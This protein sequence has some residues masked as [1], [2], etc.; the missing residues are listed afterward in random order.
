[1]A[2]LK[3]TTLT[4]SS[5][6]DLRVLI[7]APSGRDADLI[8]AALQ[9]VRVSSHICRSAGEIVNE[10]K[11]GA[12]AAVLSE[13]ALGESQI[14]DISS[15]L[16]H[17][18]PWSDLPI[19]VLTGGGEP[20]RTTRRLASMR[21]PLGNL[22]LQER[23]LRSVTLVSSVQ[24]ALRA[25]EKQYEVRDHLHEL[26]LR[27]EALRRAEEQFRQLA[28]AMPQL[29]WITDAEGRALW[30]ND[31]WF[32]YTGKT[33]EQLEGSGW[34][35]LHDPE[36]LPQVLQ[37]WH[38]CVRKGAP[39][40]MEFPL[41][42]AD[43]RFR[44]FLTRVI[45][46]RD[47]QGK[48]TRWLGTNTDIHAQREAREFLRSNKERLES[49]VAKRTAALRQLSTKL[50]RAQDE[51]R[52]RLAR[53][54][55][56]SMGQYLAAMSMSLAALVSDTPGIDKKR[57]DDLQNI[58][59][60][61]LSETRTLSHLLHPPLLDEIGLNSA[62]KWFVEEF[63][64]RSGI[65]VTLHCEGSHRL[66]PLVETMLFRI[67]QEALTN[68][69]KHSDSPTAEV[70]L[71]GDGDGVVLEVSDQGKGIP[72][73]LLERLGNRGSVA[74]VGLAGMRERVFEIGGDFRLQSG[75]QGTSIRVSIPLAL[76][77]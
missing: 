36:I 39:F 20:N 54:L 53:E 16:S 13:E 64:N 11:R 49:E 47:Q 74:G 75:P 5:N 58:I 45:P 32:A 28:N 51:E 67:V 69:H 34:Q 15:A 43:G 71:H 25:R 40:E 48:V 44:W 72:K 57:S 14:Q 29:A 19:I 62:M 26:Q 27:G 65:R 21:V 70:S 35:S 41:R 3:V 12:A 63:G 10:L 30:Y 33:F 2:T 7:L 4:P 24:A 50:I 77:A 68:I 6:H 9:D 76:A 31:G 18:P 61:C 23:P 60:L 22:T 52:R 66:P 73:D 56:D 59:Q 8:S 55:H 37:R 17:Q 1:M 42:G 46:I 38:E